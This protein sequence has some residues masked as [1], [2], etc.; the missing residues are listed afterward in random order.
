MLRWLEVHCND[1]LFNIY[2]RIVASTEDSNFLF[3][4]ALKVPTKRYNLILT[5]I[6]YSIISI[7]II[8]NYG[9][10]RPYS[11]SPFDHIIK[12]AVIPINKYT[13]AL[14]LA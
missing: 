12:Q 4:P 2:S 1:T 11:S 7:S 9:V 6:L 13:V 14:I 5:F 10:V 3:S 8:N